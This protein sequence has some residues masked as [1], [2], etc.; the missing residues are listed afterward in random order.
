MYFIPGGLVKGLVEEFLLQA[1]LV[2]AKPLPSGLKVS[3]Y[4][5]SKVSSLGAATV[6]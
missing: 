2:E 6:V 3:K 4:R 5:A 1:F